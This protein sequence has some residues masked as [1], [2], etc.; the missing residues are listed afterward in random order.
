MVKPCEQR[1][2]ADLAH[3]AQAGDR[4]AFD[5]LTRRHAAAVLRL[6]KALT[7][8]AALAE[9][10][11]QQA[12]LAAFRGIGGFRGDASLR[13]WL[14][15]ITRHTAYRMRAK[16]AKERP[17]DEPLAKLGEDAGWGSPDPETLAILAQRRTLLKRALD[18][19]S[20]SDREVLVLRDI[21]QVTGPEA[22]AI[23]GLELR[24]TK[25]RLHRA[26]LRLAAALRTLRADEGDRHG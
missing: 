26:R 7:G 13:T 17:V 16:H 23:L 19:L 14:L 15:T 10:V 5:Q 6:A 12:F 8:N 25:S 9:D 11:T 1:S 20:A 3:A 22:A 21:E 18:S 24:A 4:R 2:D